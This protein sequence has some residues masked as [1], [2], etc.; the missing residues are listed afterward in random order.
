MA[1]TR[2]KPRRRSEPVPLHDRSSVPRV[3][4]PVVAKQGAVFLLSAENG[5]IEEDSD[6][7]LYFHDMRFLSACTLRLDG[8]VPVALLADASEG[9]RTLFELTNLDICDASGDVRLPKETLV[10]RRDRTLGD[11]FTES[12]TV[13]NYGRADADFALQLRYAADFADMFV[14][15]GMHP[16][17]RGT[18]HPPE[19]K[20]ACLTFR[21]DGADGYA[22]TAALLFSNAPDTQKDGQLTYRLRIHSQQQWELKV[23]GQL[24]HAGRKGLESRPRQTG[25]GSAHRR[26]LAHA[27]S[28]GGRTRVE[29]DNQLF[30]AI[31]TRSFLDL[32]MLSMH[33]KEQTFF[34][35]GVPWYVALFGRDSLVTSIETA[36]F[37]PSV[38]ANTLRI[39]ARHQASQT[40]DWRDAQPGK[41]LHELRVDELANLREIPQT[42]YYGSV[43]STPLFLALLGMHFAWTGTLDLFHDLQP[44]VRAA[45]DWIEQYG[46]SDGDGF[47]DYCSR[48]ASG[49]RNQGWKDSGNGIVMDD[50]RLAEPPIA[51][52]EVQGDVYLAWQSMA[53]VFECDG[54]TR[55]A[56]HLRQK[57][58]RLYA[59]FNDQFWLRDA[60][61][62][63]LCRQADG[64]FSR[65]IASNPAH[66][67]WTGIVDPKRA[68]AVV[69]RVLRPDMFSGWGIRTLSADDRSYNPVDYQVGSVWPHDNAIIVAG[70][71]RYGFDSAA[72]RVFT[73]IMQAAA[74]FEHFR[75]PEVFAGHDRGL[76]SKP[77]KYPVACNPQAWA[78]GAIPFM[79]TCMLG[80]HPDAFHR[81]LHIRHAALPEW[82]A[83][84]NLHAVRVGQAE[85]DLRYERSDKTTVVAVT[86][87]RGDVLVSVE[88]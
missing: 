36:A 80:L 15:R 30:N 2:R 20:D 32:H 29:T 87:K 48:S 26:Q 60:G 39:L 6:Q 72:N 46:D 69:Q 55:T 7:G 83:W 77:V 79:L 41:I 61:Y 88:N 58:Q 40:D 53:D 44:S 52:P 19:W 78:A 1:G 12:I 27:G 75:L 38:S 85:V 9:N 13:L 8:Y 43:D 76:A 59:A 56:E 64:R 57:A 3:A 68:R 82:L 67:L 25:G 37:E 10:I 71:Q 11:D 14:V 49:A 4:Q 42:P 21:Y 70:M 50:G 31:M 16:G 45:L 23:T 17:Q 22:R 81:R 84:V 18:L 63:A 66:A 54:D 34:A 62:F 5:D 33:E 73:A 35:A 74:Q 47:V 65:S 51:L 28:L 24:H 86:R